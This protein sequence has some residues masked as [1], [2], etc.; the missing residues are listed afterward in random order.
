MYTRPKNTASPWKNGLGAR[1]EGGL[2]MAEITID[3][4]L[5]VG[6]GGCNIFCPYGIL[7]LGDGQAVVVTELLENCNECGA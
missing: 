2:S 6:C 1:C 5:C 3:L 7:D 4:S